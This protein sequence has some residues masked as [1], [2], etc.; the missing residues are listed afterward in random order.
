MS[1]HPDYRGDFRQG[2][3]SEVVTFQLDSLFST[4]PCSKVMGK[5]EDGSLLFVYPPSDWPEWFY[6]STQVQLYVFISLALIVENYWTSG[7]AYLKN[8][9]IS[10]YDF[11]WFG[12]PA[13]LKA[14]QIRFQKSVVILEHTQT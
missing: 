12:S 10:L 2:L 13:S 1:I 5:K 6:S 14:S 3:N 4:R 9:R 11:V 7:G 8:Q